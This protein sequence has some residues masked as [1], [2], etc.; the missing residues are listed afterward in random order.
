M[1]G[2]QYERPR[3]APMAYNGVS[4]AD[5]SAHEDPIRS[6]IREGLSELFQPRIGDAVT[7]TVSG[8]LESDLLE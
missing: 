5:K 2:G 6:L 8:V 1:V 4:G 7:S 3:I